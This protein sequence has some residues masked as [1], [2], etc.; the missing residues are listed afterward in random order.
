MEAATKRQQA[1]LQSLA[2]NDNLI[3]VK[4]FAARFVCSEKTIRNDLQAL[5]EQ[6]VIIERVSGKGIRLKAGGSDFALHPVKEKGNRGE[7]STEHRR[8]EIF[9][10]L[11]NGQQTYCSI[12]SLADK[13]FVSKTSIV[14]DLTVIERQLHQYNIVLQKNVHGTK[15]AGS[16][17]D[18]RKALVDIL[19]YLLHNEKP[20][21]QGMYLRI[22]T[23]TLT[24]LH[25]HFEQQSI[26]VVE[27]IVEQAESI[28]GYQIVEPYYIN[29]ITHIL[30]SIERIR[31]NKLLHND[32]VADSTV[33]KSPIYEAAQYIAAELSVNFAIE[34][35][36]AE[37]F[38][39]YRYL[40]SSGGKNYAL[41]KK[42]LES[43]EAET[44]AMEIIDSCSHVFPLKFSFSK[45]L[46]QALLLHLQPMLNR[47]KYSINIKNPMLEQI[48][49]EFPRIMLLLNLIM[50][51]IRLAHHLPDIHEDEIAY[52]AVYFQDAFEE[53]LM[54]KKAVIVCSSGV[55]TSHLLKKRIK[56]VFPELNILDVVSAKY[57][58]DTLREHSVDIVIT[59]VHLD[60]PLPLPVVYVNA[61]FSKAD[62]AKVKHIFHQQ[63]PENMQETAAKITGQKITTQPPELANLTPTF[64]IKPLI[65]LTISVYVE[66]GLKPGWKIMQR[67]TPHIIIQLAAASQLNDDM[68]KSIYYWVEQEKRGE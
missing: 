7:S 62:E 45:A 24:E 66:K 22:D 8:L 58:E 12:Q 3:P 65:D 11:L 20:T 13:Y 23:A 61:F 33:R 19:G 64:Q 32:L 5:E 57:V 56:N 16:E 47:I 21:P 39:I 60:K 43:S 17:V 52:L 44:M 15:I 54:H 55:G 37:I 4:E 63:L 31:S 48:K 27:H 29:L 36:Q 1:L 26:D 6:G 35:N 53:A 67:G 30:I 38:Y 34:L 49:M 2:S 40:S 68:I 42:N 50:M 25:R 46:Y 10:E 9:F 41:D 28:L 14:N 51:R 59:T 18:I